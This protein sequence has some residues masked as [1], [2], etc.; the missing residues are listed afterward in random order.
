MRK[1]KYIYTGRDIQTV[2]NYFSRIVDRVIFWLVVFGVFMTIGLIS[3]MVRIPHYAI[4]IVVVVIFTLSALEMVSFMLKDMIK[5]SVACEKRG[6]IQR[7][8]KKGD[9]LVAD[10]KGSIPIL[11]Q[12]FPKWCGK[13]MVVR[14]HFYV[15]VGDETYIIDETTYKT[16]EEGDEVFIVFSSRGKIFLDLYPLKYDV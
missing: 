14:P 10:T 7:K 2:Q 16:V 5:C 6:V 11:G 12:F 1:I 13:K 4:V 15:E 3:K 9:A 8:Y